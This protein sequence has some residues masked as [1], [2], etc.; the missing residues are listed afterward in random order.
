MLKDTIKKGKSKEYGKIYSKTIQ[1]K[2]LILI[3]WIANHKFFRLENTTKILELEDG[4]IC[5]KRGR[6]IYLKIG[7]DVE[8]FTIKMVK[9]RANGLR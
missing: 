2:I 4:I 1:S 6:W 7:I 9:S 5:N 3:L 8:G